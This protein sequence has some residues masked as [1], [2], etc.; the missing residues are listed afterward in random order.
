MTVAVKLTRYQMWIDGGWQ[1]SAS[2]ET[3]ER[4]SPADTSQ[5]ISTYPRA[6]A[7][8]VDAAVQAARTAF[9]T[10]PWPHLPAAERAHIL[11]QVGVRI[12]EVADE[13]AAIEAQEAG[14]T[15]KQARADIGAAV[16]HWAYASALARTETGEMVR[17]GTDIIGLV[18]REP[19]GVAALITPWNFPLAILC[20]KLPYALAAG[21]TTICK[22]SE[23]TSATT[24][25]LAELASEVGVP[26][27]VINVVTGFGGEAGDALVKHPGVDKISFTG[28]TAVGQRILAAAAPD[29]KR[30][31][32]ELGGKAPSIVFEDAPWEEAVH[33]VVFG[34][35]F[36]QG[37]C[38]VSGSRLLVQRSI[39]ESFT[40][41]VCAYA[42][43]LKVGDPLDPSTDVGPLVNE[44]QLN[45]VM[46][47]IEA[48]RESAD[49]LLGGDRP[50]DATMRQGWYVNPTI[51]VNV[52]PDNPLA[53]EEIFGPVLSILTFDTEEEA[54]RLAN[55][56][57]YG[58]AAAV[59]TNDV[60]RSLRLAGQIKAGTVWVNT[61]VT[62][63]PELPFGGYKQSGLN[64][65]MGREGLEDFTEVKSIQ[66][67]L[68]KQAPGF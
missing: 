57:R 6:T 10:G 66:I 48:G 26:A 63:F 22:P 1:A 37:E 13:L 31:S 38:C 47:Y 11:L 65:E 32:L 12:R 41:A 36:N 51:F 9:D 43:T 14:K 8:D 60:A 28:S 4:Q 16:D 55:N 29:I 40:D 44:M 20:Q 35:Y 34:V 50:S 30:V 23:F 3:F 39:S 46:G 33:G 18:T 25:R 19:V 53:C 64:R 17:V 54:V 24:L 61:Y 2:R 59:W 45:K 67:H 56:S 5:I 68:K 49:L 62:A 52:R 42:K 27:G 21:C 58:L 15:L 7:V